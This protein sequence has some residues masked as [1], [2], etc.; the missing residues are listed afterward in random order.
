M[1]VIVARIKIEGL[2]RPSSAARK[3]PIAIL[4]KASGSV[5]RRIACIHAVNCDDEFIDP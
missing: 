2:K 4:A 3:E 5:R 1:V